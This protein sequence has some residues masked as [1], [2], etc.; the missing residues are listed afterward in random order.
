MRSNKPLSFLRSYFSVRVMHLKAL[1]IIRF[2]PVRNTRR[3]PGKAY[4][5]S[6]PIV[7]VFVLSFLRLLQKWIYV[8]VGSN[9]LPFSLGDSLFFLKQVGNI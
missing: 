5:K 9:I 7:E 4:L 8:K 1:C 6:H 3:L 2:F